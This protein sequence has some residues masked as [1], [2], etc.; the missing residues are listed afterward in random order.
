M[1]YTANVFI[2]GKHSTTYYSIAC[3]IFK[4]YERFNGI[5][6]NIYTSFMVALREFRKAVHCI[7]HCR[8]TQSLLD[9]YQVLRCIYCFQPSCNGNLDLP[10]DAS[11][12]PAGS[13]EQEH[14]DEV[15]EAIKH[16][17]EPDESP[18]IVV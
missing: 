5:H 17:Q 6:V 12:I 11:L 3:T 8:L 7:K 2:S 16:L 10:E 13:T 14:T 15:K 4:E 1:L 18:I 9:T